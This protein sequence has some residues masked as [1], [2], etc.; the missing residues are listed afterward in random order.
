MF[1]KWLLAAPLLAF[2]L[3]GGS[4]RAAHYV[5]KVGYEN[6]PGEHIDM[7]VRLWKDLAEEKTGGKL[8]LQPYPSSQ[9]GFKSEVFKQMRLGYPVVTIADG[10]FLSSFI[11]DMAIVTG[12]YLADAGNDLFRLVECDWW[13][14]LE[15]DLEAHG[16]KII[17]YN[18]L[19]G[20]RHMVV[21]QP[22]ARFEDLAGLRIRVPNIRTHIEAIRSLGAIPVAMPLAE[23]HSALARGVIDGS[24]SPL[25]ILYGHKHHEHAKNLVVTGHMQSIACFVGSAEYLNNLPPDI[26]EVFVETARQAGLYSQELAKNIDAESIVKMGDEGVVICRPDLAPFHEAVKS[27]YELFPDWSPGL[28]EKARAAMDA[29]VQRD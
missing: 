2:L 16:Y 20:T 5:I 10:G 17:T 8:V 25:P 23:V 29:G 4:S 7:A 15:R 11:P 1:C 24:E 19:Y 14:E 12:P 9:L 27:V 28:Y 3:I 22:V 26:Y 21:N 18:F 13:K 6:H